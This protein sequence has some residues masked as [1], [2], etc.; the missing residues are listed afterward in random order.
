MKPAN[1][2]ITLNIIYLPIHIG[3]YYKQILY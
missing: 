2:H 1:Q 3:V